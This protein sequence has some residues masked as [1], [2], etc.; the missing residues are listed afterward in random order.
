MAAHVCLPAPS[1][2]SLGAA[3]AQESGTHSELPWL[4][5]SQP[6]CLSA[7]APHALADGTEIT[8][9]GTDSRKDGRTPTELENVNRASGKT[10]TDTARPTAG[11][12]ASEQWFSDVLRFILIINHNKKC[13]LRHNPINTHSLRGTSVRPRFHE[14]INL[15]R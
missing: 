10:G 6:F 3:E 8:L 4:T 9:M 7:V 2:P 5:A 15:F 1:T 13:I 12:C 14:M 11:A